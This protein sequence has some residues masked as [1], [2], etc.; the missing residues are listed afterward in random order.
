MASYWSART[1]WKPM[2]SGAKAR[3][4]WKKRGLRNFQAL[5]PP[6]ALELR[7]VKDMTRRAA[8]VGGGGGSAA[9]RSGLSRRVTEMTVRRSWVRFM[10]V[11]SA[12]VGADATDGGTESPRPTDRKRAG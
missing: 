11:I 4:V 7:T 1:S 9:R 10:G 3:M 6:W 12:R 2:R 5:S 8:D